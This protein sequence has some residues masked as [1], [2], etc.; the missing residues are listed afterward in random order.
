MYSLARKILFTLSGEAAHQ[1]ALESLDAAARLHLIKTFA[2]PMLQAPVEV[3]GLT[4]P[5][6]VGLA[7]GLDKNADHLNS[8]GQLGFGF[9]EVGTVTPK[10]QPGNPRPR[11][12]RIPEQE[13]IIN[14]MGFNNKG[15]EH[16]LQQVK[17]RQYQGLLGINL[18][19]NL[20][21]PVEKAV[22][23]YLIG[24]EAVYTQADYVTV[25]ISSPNTPG[26]RSLQYG[27]ALKDL[28]QPLKE[29]QQ[30][31]AD[32]HQRYVPLVVKVAP[33]MNDEELQSLAR[34]LRELKLD[35]VIATNTT[36]DKT[37]V[38]GL[39]YGDEQGGLS[40]RP[41]TEK[42]NSITRKLANALEGELPIIGVGGIFSAEDAVARIKAGA[43]LIQLYTG[44]IYRGP[45]L[46]HE[47]AEAIAAIKD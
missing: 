21:T 11:L 41:L 16:L 27:E 35:G 14:R 20:T 32:L 9:I 13:A 31:L 1:L 5:N 25:N 7:A 42:A 26:L 18:G 2:S 8:L 47:C 37:A 44:F 45:G 15:L 34:T 38:E 36:L 6:A 39:Q 43:S 24:L 40:G 33:D 29:A 17:K 23:D 10:P 28:L 4:F 46:I 22:D 12:F 3:M 30:R 19:K